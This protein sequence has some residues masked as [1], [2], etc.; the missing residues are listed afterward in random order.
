MSFNL[1]AFRVSFLLFLLILTLKGTAAADPD[2]Y[3]SVQTEGIGV[4]DGPYPSF[5]T[6][7]S[8]NDTDTITNLALDATGT[9]QGTASVSGSTGTLSGSIS[10]N[11]SGS[12]VAPGMARTITEV[13]QSYTAYVRAGK[14][15]T[16]SAS[17]TASAQANLTQE[18]G[19]ISGGY[20]G[21]DVDNY[22]GTNAYA[23]V[24]SGGS[25]SGGGSGSGSYVNHGSCGA[26]PT[27]Y[28]GIPGGTSY[29]DGDAQND[30]IGTMSASE[31]LQLTIEIGTDEP[32][33]SMVG[34]KVSGSVV[35]N[36]PAGASLTFTNTS[37]D[38]DDG[39]TP[40]QMI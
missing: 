31:S 2:V 32:V 24:I 13:S 10:L 5:T 30:F 14:T 19:S 11:Y 1:N 25:D 35:A 6:T 28:R 9:W 21:N 18:R 16:V 8:W 40:M 39:I 33:A 27:S 38:P 12:L 34:P 7:T 4:D 29:A 15:A 37:V 23:L 26:S 3:F 17:H 20:N 22:S 36:P